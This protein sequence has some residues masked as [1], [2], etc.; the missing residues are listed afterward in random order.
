MGGSVL[1]FWD[2]SMGF[3]LFVPGRM[4][5]CTLGSMVWEFGIFYDDEDWGPPALVV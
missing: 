5:T 3:L 4:A 2:G 1:E